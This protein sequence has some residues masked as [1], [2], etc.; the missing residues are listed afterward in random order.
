MKDYVEKIKNNCPAHRLI[1]WW[2]MRICL[3]GGLGMSIAG[4]KNAPAEA[5]LLAL[6]FGF[7]FFPEIMLLS[8]KSFFR[9]IPSF[10]HS[11]CL[12]LVVAGV[13]GG[14]ALGLADRFF[15]WDWAIHFICGGAL[16]F[17]GYEYACAIAK[18]D[19]HGI[20]KAMA[21]FVAFGLF[22]AV[23]SLWELGEFFID[24]LCGAFT[25]TVGNLQGWSF[26][27]VRGTAAERNFFEPIVEGRWPLMNTM[28]DIVLDTIG[29]FTALLIVNIFPYRH[30]GKF[31]YDLSFGKGEQPVAA[32]L[33]KEKAKD[34]FRAYSLR[35]KNN[36]PP[37]TYAF[38]WVIRLMMI[39]LL[40]YTIVNDEYD[41]YASFQVIANLCCMFIWEL[42]MAMPPKNVFRYIPPMLQTVVTVLDFVAVVAGLVFNF[43]YTVR[44]WDSALHLMTGFFGVFFAYEIVYA[45]IKMEKK[46]AS[47]AVV[48][49]CTMGC[50][51]MLEAFWELFEFSYD[52]VQGLLSGYPGDAQHW[53]ALLAEGT[54]KSKTLFKSFDSGRWPLMDTMG[55]IFLNTIG[56][57]SG[58]L[59]LKLMPY[60]SKGKFRY[61]FDFDKEKENIK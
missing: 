2:I 25:G 54:E 61:I 43:Y 31:S 11:L 30:R 19:R 15:W 57:F 26:E 7:S 44:F 41:A 14:Y 8:K 5:V 60:R 53:S 36:C 4:E 28:S 18:R 29:A 23:I 32:I 34:F 20:T 59:I 6:S 56:I 37:R 16:V 38:W 10:V 9:F 21:F 39:G 58:T 27:A 12:S 1:F 55:D 13:F 40:V 48:L 47:P 42:V 35:L 52:H 22:F 24:Q 51:F 17:V 49:I 45:L 50:I 33:P 3:L 46:T